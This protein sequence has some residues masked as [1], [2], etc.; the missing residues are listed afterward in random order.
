M[1]KRYDVSY[2]DIQ[3]DFNH[4]AYVQRN[5]V[6]M[7]TVTYMNMTKGTGKMQI[8]F[9]GKNSTY[10]DAFFLS[11]VISTFLGTLNI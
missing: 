9:A 8:D 11:F 10:C 6:M 7:F 1:S 5:D 2:V 4:P 3:D